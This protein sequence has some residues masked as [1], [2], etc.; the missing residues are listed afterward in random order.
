MSNLYFNK[1]LKYKTKYLELLK[2]G[3]S[4]L[5]NDFII[6]GKKPTILIKIRM[7][8]LPNISEL[9]DTNPQFDVEES[10]SNIEESQIDTEELSDIEPRNDSCPKPVL[11]DAMSEVFDHLETD[12]KIIDIVTKLTYKN[13]ELLGRK[14]AFGPVPTNSWINPQ[15]LIGTIPYTCDEIK[16]NID[17][18][19]ITAFLSLR[20]HNEPY[21]QCKLDKAKTLHFGNKQKVNIDELP[22][23]YNNLIFL[24]YRIND[25]NTPTSINDTIAAIDNIINYIKQNPNNKVMIHCWG[26]HGR[27]GTFT[28][29]ILSVLLL[30]TDKD[31][32]DKIASNNFITANQEILSLVDYI[33]NIIQAYIMV[34]L[35]AYRLTDSQNNKKD[36]LS[37]LIPETHAQDIFV[38]DIIKAYIMKYLENKYLYSI[39]NSNPLLKDP[40]DLI[41]Q[42]TADENKLLSQVKGWDKDQIWVK[43]T[44]SST[45][46]TCY[47]KN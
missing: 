1:Y 22:K 5:D 34:N 17:Y 33:F 41:F 37:I 36:I 24:R 46:Q 35:R 27:T 7:N 42:D 2:K 28:A 6:G 47:N 11:I 9:S 29:C 10:E 26:G 38:K 14:D 13:L 30:D 16:T 4:H 40:K 19:K 25:F 18:G 39:D 43:P 8:S 23:E 12:E 44:I 21:T 32:M 3:R 20:E 31:T 45:I 15:I